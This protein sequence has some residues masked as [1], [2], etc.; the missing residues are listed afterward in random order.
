MKSGRKN[1]LGAIPF[2]DAGTYS[3]DRFYSLSF[4]QIAKAGGDHICIG[5]IGDPEHSDQI[6][7]KIRPSVLASEDRRLS[8]EWNKKYSSPEVADRKRITESLDH[9]DR[10]NLK[11]TDL[12]CLVFVNPAGKRVGLLRVLDH[13]YDSEPSWRVFLRCLCSWL[14]QESVIEL[15]SS[16]LEDTVLSR[17]LAERLGGLTSEVEEQLEFLDSTIGLDEEAWY[18]HDRLAVLFQVNKETLRK[19]LERNQLRDDASWR[20][21]EDPKPGESAY[22]YRLRNVKHIIENLRVSGDRPAE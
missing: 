18:T 13:W 20:K 12:P 9:F 15:A 1:K 14:E 11:D 7:M 21:C 17:R 4:D 5:R 3:F 19:R 10:F 8:R 16:N 22:L 2:L 6:Y